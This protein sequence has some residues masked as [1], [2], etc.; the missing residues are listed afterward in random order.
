MI[1]ALNA[2]RAV[3]A[4]TDSDPSDATVT[5]V[6]YLDAKTDCT[7]VDACRSMLDRCEV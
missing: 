3:V 4:I 2:H 1:P 7:T 5:V 6:V